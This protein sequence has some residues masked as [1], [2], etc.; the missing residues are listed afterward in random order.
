MSLE[1]IPEDQP[2]IQQNDTPHQDPKLQY[3]LTSIEREQSS[4]TLD[5]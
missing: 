4:M 3:R 2:R 1:I 5:E